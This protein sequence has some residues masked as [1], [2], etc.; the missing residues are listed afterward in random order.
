MTIPDPPD[1][2]MPICNIISCSFLLS[3]ISTDKT[4]L[5]ISGSVRIRQTF[6]SPKYVVIVAAETNMQHLR[7]FTAL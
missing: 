4:G 2:K 6:L 1:G 7:S 5:G 3:V